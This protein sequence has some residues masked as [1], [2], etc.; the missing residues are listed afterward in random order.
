MNIFSIQ[1][2]VFDAW[3]IKQQFDNFDVSLIASCYKW[4]SSKIIIS[5]QFNPYFKTLNFHAKNVMIIPLSQKF[6]PQWC[7]RLA[8]AGVCSLFKKSSW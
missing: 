5:I 6:R 4:S 1:I 3:L 2:N 7:I 8:G